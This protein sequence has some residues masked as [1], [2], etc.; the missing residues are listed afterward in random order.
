MRKFVLSPLH[1]SLIG[2]KVRRVCEADID[3]MFGWTSSLAV[4][5]VTL[6]V[7]YEPERLW[8]LRGHNHMYMNIGRMWVPLVKVPHF[9]F[10]RFGDFGIF[11]LALF[12]PSL[13]AEGRD[14]GSNHHHN[15]FVCD[16]VLEAFINELLLPAVKTE[17]GP[18]VMHHISQDFG[19]AKLM[20]KASGKA[21][22]RTVHLQPHL[23]DA[24]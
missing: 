22:R 11:R 2:V 4:S 15:N 18:C 13:Y 17:C 1:P 20:N 21:Y 6:N 24:I 16:D 14:G 10:A 12:L 7:S 23:L 3:S 5:R 19:M 9:M 8:N